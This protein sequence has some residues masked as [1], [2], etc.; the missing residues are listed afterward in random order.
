[1]VTS[2]PPSH[3]LHQEAMRSALFLGSWGMAVVFCITYGL[4]YPYLTLL[5]ETLA[6]GSIGLAW[7]RTKRFAHIRITEV[8][9]APFGTLFSFCSLMGI[10]AMLWVLVAVYFVVDNEGTGVFTTYLI[11]QI[12]SEPFREAFRQHPL[13]VELSRTTNGKEIQVLVEGVRAFKRTDALTL[14][15]FANLFL[16]PLISSVIS[17]LCSKRR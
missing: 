11:A 16:N 8:G 12:E 14:L 2:S 13:F 1:M 7:Y 15:L 4:V 10:Y 6:V 5:G 17:L 3:N 9:T